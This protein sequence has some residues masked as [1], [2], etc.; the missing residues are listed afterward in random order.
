[1]EA[2]EAKVRQALKGLGLEALTLDLART[3]SGKLTG[4]VI[5]PSFVGLDQLE[6]QDRVWAALEDALTAEELTQVVSLITV[7]PDEHGLDDVAE[8]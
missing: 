7:T 5:S 1:M 4:F 6:R 8:G 2:I 3:R